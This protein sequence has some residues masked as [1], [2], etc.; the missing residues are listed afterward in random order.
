M[1]IEGHYPWSK[2]P[3]YQSYLTVGPMA[4][5]AED[6]GLLLDVMGPGAE[7]P[8][9]AAVELRDVTVFTCEQFER[10]VA[11]TD[12]RGEIREG[13]RKSAEFL[14]RARGCARGEV[15]FDF[16][17]SFEMCV[18]IFFEIGD[19]PN[20]LEH[21]RKA[22]RDSLP[23]ELLKSAFRR[24]DYSFNLLF[25]YLA[26]RANGL[27]PKRRSRFYS[28]IAGIMKKTLLEK[29]GASGVLLCP[30]FPT[31]A[32]RHRTSPLNLSNITYCMLF[33]ILGLPGTH[34]PLGLDGDGLPYGIQVVA[35]PNRDRLCIAVAKELE[36]AFGG[37]KPPT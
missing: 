36:D 14:R 16:R 21:N 18:S 27:V 9:G 5:Y 2:D 12:V 23:L 30:T 3:V 26:H 15:N 8:D 1:P 4:R 28:R 34:V 37:W 10:S 24:S 17:S 6:L 31:T 33:N 25:F 19:V 35:A 13:I 22:R 11:F 29:L 32:F 20:A 7:G